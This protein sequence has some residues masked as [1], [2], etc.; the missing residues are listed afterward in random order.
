MCLPTHHQRLWITAAK[1]LIFGPQCPF[2]AMVS[3][4]VFQKEPFFIRNSN[5]YLF[6]L[7]L[8]KECFCSDFENT[9]FF[10]YF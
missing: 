10:L 2:L 5:H 3:P 4:F 8:K 6:S 7:K 1:T 9:S